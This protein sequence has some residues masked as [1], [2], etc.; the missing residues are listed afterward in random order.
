MTRE[1]REGEGEDVVT[2][3]VEIG[4]APLRLHV[5]VSPR[6][7]FLLRVSRLPLL[8]VPASP[9]LRVHPPPLNSQSGR[10]LSFII[11]LGIPTSG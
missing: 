4:L 9:L 6:P 5:S 2:R 3:E 8:R 1:G 7:P 10:I 11:N